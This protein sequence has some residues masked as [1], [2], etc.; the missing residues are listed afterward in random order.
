MASQ[1]HVSFFFPSAQKCMAAHSE[2]V[3]YAG[4]SDVQRS[5]LDRYPAFIHAKSLPSAR[6]GERGSPAAG[7]TQNCRHDQKLSLPP[8]SLLPPQLASLRVAAQPWPRGAQ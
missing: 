1:E 7:A 5:H 8:V 4:S 3:N 6:P 2:A